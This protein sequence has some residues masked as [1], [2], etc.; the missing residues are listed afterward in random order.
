MSPPAPLIRGR[1]W[2]GCGA[3]PLRRGRPQWRLFQFPSRP[4]GGGL[5]E[6]EN[7]SK[8]HPRMPSFFWFWAHGGRPLGDVALFLATS[9]LGNFEALAFCGRIARGSSLRIFRRRQRADL[10]EQPR[11][12]HR[13]G[14]EVV[15]TG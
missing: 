11:Q 10:A 2:I 13:L 6:S 3:T 4:P 14:I 9:L 5:S 7:Y 1:G 8:P 15:A 12:L